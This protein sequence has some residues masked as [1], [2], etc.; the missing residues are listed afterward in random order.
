M[1]VDRFRHIILPVQPQSLDYSGRGGGESRIPKRDRHAHSRY[2]MERLAK[3]WQD[4]DYERAVI[5]AQR[6][7][8]YLEF[9]SDPDA[10]LVTKSLEN[11]KAGVRLLN[12]RKEI[13]DGSEIT[14]ATVYV[15]NSSR[16]FFADRIEQYAREETE[17]GRPRHAALVE[18]IA[19]VR[20]ALLESFW[21]DDRTLLPRDEP[22]WCEVWLSSHDEDVHERFL[23]MTENEGISVRPGSIVFPERRVV[24]IR[25]NWDQLERLIQLSDDIAELRRAKE[26]A[27]FW[28][29]LTNVEQSDW[30]RDLL[31][32]L[33]VDPL[34]NVALCLLDTGVNNGHPL[35]E[36]V[37]SDEDLLTVDPNWGTHDHD[38]H[39]TQMAGIAAYGDL[40]R[41][42]TSSDTVYVAHRLESCK[43]L[44][45]P[46]ATNAPELWGLI[47]SQAVSRAEIN[48]PDRTRIICCAVTANDTR[49]RG[50]P[51]SWSGQLDKL[52][53]G[54]DDGVRRLIIV[55]AGNTDPADAMPYPANQIANSIQDP[56]QAWNVLT[57]GAYSELDQIRDAEYQVY[58][59]VAARGQLS[60]FSST[61]ESW[62]TI[63]PNKPDVVFEGG[64]LGVDTTGF[65]TECAD[66]SLLSTYHN[67]AQA[68]FRSFNMT[69]AAT[70]QAGWFAA[71]IQ[72]EY[73]DLWPETVRALIVHSARWTDAMKA[74]FL[75]DE[76]KRSY[77]R[78]LRICGYGVPD[79]DRAL[80]SA[81][82]SLTLLIQQDIQPYRREASVTK[83]NE[84][85]LFELPWP[86]EVL[87]EHGSLDVE[88]RV[89][90]SYFIE[91]GP[92]EVG[93]KDRYRYAS[94]GLRFDV[95]APGE[96]AN[97]FVK[98][99]N[100]HMQSEEI[101]TVSSASTSDY[102]VI[103]S[104]ARD[105]GSL[106][107]DIWRGSAADLATGGIIAVYPIGGWWRERSHLGMV[108]KRTRYSLI[109]SITTPEQ[110]VDLYTPIANELKIPV[111]VEVP[112][113]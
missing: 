54:A 105:R 18:S 86:R 62:E 29:N 3:A 69:S 16:R 110:E 76:S 40:V 98:R 35:L 67:M 2:L 7:G 61:S 112:G 66:L 51:S 108:D 53:S 24:L 60:P 99:I 55:A 32:R 74:Q 89:T 48:A 83:F 22:A 30:V 4:A 111:R 82:N 19:D 21:Q 37:L 88:M 12:V 10:D 65:V 113:F 72:N 96:D 93:W 85:H 100:R 26:L 102:W 28:D 11:L 14:L 9:K 8:V 95:N 5:H 104:N 36:P 43:I 101:A 50:R 80:Y 64:N 63:W 71:Q 90:L 87:L 42:L 47:T 79:L 75:R 52:A 6:D 31:D 23:S 77:A 44:P 68:Y 41:H 103:G 73:P 57:V 38:G 97:A 94:H 25:A 109:V 78:L 46:P 84:M 91:P 33:E 59:P 58:T 49:D 106:H 70:A 107:S 34:N 56:A 15:P 92:G 81:R 17:G 27:S 45:P 39:G 20:K 1:A 13:R